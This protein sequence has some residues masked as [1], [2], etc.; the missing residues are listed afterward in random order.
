MEQI[1]QSSKSPYPSMA[2]LFELLVAPVRW[3]VL[4]AA[5]ELGMAD[6]L[7]ETSSVDQ[8]AQKAGGP[9]RS[10]R[11]CLF[12]GCH[13]GP[14][15]GKQEKQCIQQHRTCQTFFVHKES[16]FHGRSFA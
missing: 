15:T 5:V 1:I 4:E 16:G 6:I 13:G 8:I 10:R 14:W 11:S 3:A 9:D 2:V 7:A 12:S